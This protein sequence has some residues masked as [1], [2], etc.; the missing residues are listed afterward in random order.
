MS[1]CPDSEQRGLGAS[2]I[3]RSRNRETPLVSKLKRCAG[4]ST[5]PLTA[6]QWAKIVAGEDDPFG[7]NDLHLLW[8]PKERFFV[9]RG[10]DGRLAAATGLVVVEAAAGGET[11]AVVG[12][13]VGAVIVSKPPRGRRLMRRVLDAALETAPSL[14]PDRAMLFCSPEN[15]ALYEHFGF[16]EIESRVVAQQPGGPVE[17]PPPAAMW[18]PLR[19]GA[20]WPAGP[21]TLPGPPF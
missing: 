12:V 2:S 10:A 13:G 16:L 6:D 15:V 5:G 17:M 21:V 19:P 11:F 18:R 8:L 14:G 3:M 1:P 9:V 4:R 7:A 20:T